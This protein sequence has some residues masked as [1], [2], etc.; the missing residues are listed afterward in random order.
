MVSVGY[1]LGTLSRWF[2]GSHSSWRALIGHGPRAGRPCLL[3]LGDADQ[4]TGLDTMQGLVDEAAGGAAADFKLEVI[5]GCDHF[6]HGKQAQVAQRVISWL[7]LI[8]C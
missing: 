1:P 4:F 5:S 8:T 6:F 7:S 2:L 3:I